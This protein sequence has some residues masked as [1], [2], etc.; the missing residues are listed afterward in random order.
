MSTQPPSSPTWSLSDEAVESVT[1]LISQARDGRSEAWDRVYS[2]LYRELHQI[3]R[4]QLR[5]RHRSAAVQSPTS[6]ISAA[7]LKLAG[8]ASTAESRSQ[9]VS[10]IAHAMRF[11]VLDEAKSV[12]AAKRG[13]GVAP[14]SL[15]D[16]SDEEPS[17]AARAEQLVLLNQSLEYLARIDARLVRIVE[18]RYFGGL[19]DKEIGTLLEVN[20]RT[21]RRDW[22]RARG[23]LVGHLG[24]ALGSID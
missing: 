11:V 21:V 8:A 2:L 23:F 19:T 17:E 1:T 22:R 15:A 12:L 7:W 14:V 18:L 20:E 3:A 16:N 4:F 9:L 10:L 24:G 6:L 5:Q 13:S